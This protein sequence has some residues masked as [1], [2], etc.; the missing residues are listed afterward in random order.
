M[1]T[2]QRINRDAKGDLMLRNESPGIQGR[3][4]AGY[5]EIPNVINLTSPEVTVPVRDLA[6]ARHFYQEVLGCLEGHGDTERIHST[7]FG[8][9]I[10]CR[11]SS[12][13]VGLHRTAQSDAAQARKATPFSIVLDRKEWH[14][15]ARRLRQHRAH[16]NIAPCI[17]FSGT[18]FEEASLSLL[19]PSGNTLE[20]R[21]SHNVNRQRSRGD[22]KNVL[23]MISFA[24]AT[25]LVWCWILL[26]AQKSVS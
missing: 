24:I 5:S 20:F 23:A 21:S 17:R 19:D 12:P 3:P 22:R 10:V 7:L 16:F 6:E 1:F 18:Q 13:W 2:N 9:P 4:T 25:A 26:L 11:L 8:Y 15:L 14:A